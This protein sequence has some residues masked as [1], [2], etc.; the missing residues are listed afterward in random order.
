M[1]YTRRVAQQRDAL[2]TDEGS[3]IFSELIDA[4]V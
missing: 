2:I 4:K 3:R 1:I